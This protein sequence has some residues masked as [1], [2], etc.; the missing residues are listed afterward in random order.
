MSVLNKDDVIKACADGYRVA[1]GTTDKV[2]IGQLGGL[3][4]ML[5]AGGG[6]GLAY[7]VGTFKLAVDSNASGSAVK[8][9]PHKLGKK[10][11]MIVV[12]TD[13]FA[14]ITDPPYSSWTTHIG[15]IWLDGLT[16]MAQRY[17]ASE[18]SNIPILIFMQ[19][20]SSDARVTVGVP[21]ATTYGLVEAPTE[22]TIPLNYLGAYNF[23]RAGVTY[24]YFVSEG[25]W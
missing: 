7:D 6:N 14:D 25:F 22:S 2:P 18:S 4:S 16:G 23:W 5:T 11:R 19:M 10:P 1:S 9:I 20:T 21:S 12:W 24:K 17:S 13:D 8:T 3:I 15:Y